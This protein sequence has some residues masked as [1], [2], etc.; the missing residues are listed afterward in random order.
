MKQVGSDERACRLSNGSYDLDI[1]LSMKKLLLFPFFLVCC[2]ALSA[3]SG[4]YGSVVSDQVQ[5]TESLVTILKGV[6]DK[7]S[8]DSA[9]S[10]VYMYRHSLEE[11]LQGIV[12]AGKPSMLDLLRLKNQLTDLKTG[13]SS[14]D[15]ISQYIRL[16]TVDFYGSA[17][18]KNAFRLGVSQ[19]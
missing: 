5:R 10:G 4:F 2:I 18:L 6:Q 1:D 17:E 12:N 9:A 7:A 11:V 19:A 16:S 3:C 15:L 8:A 14:K 13:Q